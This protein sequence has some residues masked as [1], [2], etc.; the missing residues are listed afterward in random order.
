[1]VHKVKELFSK[2]KLVAGNEQPEQDY[3]ALRRTNMFKAR[4]TAMMLSC[5][6]IPVIFFLSQVE[7]SIT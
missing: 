3:D 2:L 7:I 5:F 6:S 4:F 1:M